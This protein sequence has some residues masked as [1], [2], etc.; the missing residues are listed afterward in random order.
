M[1]GRQA[2]ITLDGTTF[3]R[4]GCLGCPQGSPLSSLFFIALINDIFTL[5]LRS[6][7]QAFEDDL[8]LVYLQKKNELVTRAK[9][10]I[11]TKWFTS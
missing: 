8:R 1:H 7:L 3:K 9:E 5:P 6:H 2:C 11:T 10:N 4:T